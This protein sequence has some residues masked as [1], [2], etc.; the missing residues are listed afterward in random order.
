M[1]KNL[2][3]SYQKVEQVTISGRETEARVLTKAAV[4]LKDCQD[5]WEAA[6]RREKMHEAL[7][8]NQRIWSWI[9]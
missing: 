5:N 8:Y 7:S 2:L 1:Y 9:P 3:D 6:D 4:M